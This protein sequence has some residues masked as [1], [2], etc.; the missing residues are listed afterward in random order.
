VKHNADDLFH[1]PLDQAQIDFENEGGETY[2]CGNPPYRGSSWQTKEQ[3]SD[4][5]HISGGEIKSWKSLDY[6]AGWVVK[7]ARYIELVP[8]RFS[9]VTT[10]SI[11]EGEQAPI[12]WPLVFSR[13]LEIEFAHVPFN[14]SNLA[15]NKAGVTVVIIGVGDGSREKRIYESSSSRTVDIIGPYLAPGS[16]A[17]VSKTMAPIGQQFKMLRGNMPTDGGRLLMSADEARAAIANN[18]VDRKF[19]R[20][21]MGASE[22]VS[23][24]PRFCLW[25]ESSD[26]D[27]AMLTPFIRQRV[28]GVHQVRMSSSA[29][30]TRSTKVPP[31]RFMQIEGVAKKFSIAIPAITSE[32]REYL[33]VSLLDGS[34]ILSNKCYA[35]YDA[36]L[37]NFAL[38]SSSLHRVWIGTVCA[39]M[40]SDY[41]YSNTLGWNTFPIPL[42]TEKNQADLNRCAE[43]ILLRRE[44]Y[45]P[46]SIAEL[47][48]P[49]D[50]PLDLAE[51]AAAFVR[52][53]DE[54]RYE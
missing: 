11:C 51:G 35:L 28:E 39:R 10:K 22:V 7:A 29:P 34:V 16:S 17:I 46:A 38:A 41:S 36:P 54:G 3:K 42:L 43:D 25:I 48:D 21:F 27:C 50:M 45:F 44:A 52:F 37:W 14:W 12:L 8:G 26:L 32:N 9:F 15:S 6:V 40:R 5:E 30:T 53:K 1:S 4:L 13:K 23:G 19:I 18:G 49:D 47:Y 31:Y 2:I 24:N 20:P 33:P